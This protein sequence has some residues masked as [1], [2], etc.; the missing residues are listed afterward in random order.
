MH[1]RAGA[2]DPR[3]DAGV[4]TGEVTELVGEHRAQLSERKAVQQRQAEPQHARGADAQD[5]ADVSDEGVHVG[6]EVDVPRSLHAAA[7]G[8]AIDFLEERGVKLAL[9]LG[10][11]RGEAAGAG[12]E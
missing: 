12:K 7:R 2:V 11:W 4:A 1:G 5:T 10:A 6:R 9:E 3:A 8:H